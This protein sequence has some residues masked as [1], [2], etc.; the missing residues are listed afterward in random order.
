MKREGGGGKGTWV[1]LLDTDG[2]SHL[3]WN[4]PNHDSDCI[5]F[6]KLQEPY[7]LVGSAISPHFVK[8]L[9]SMAMD[10]H[11]KEK[12]VASVLLSALYA[13]VI[14][15]V[16]ISQ[17]S[18]LLLEAADDL[19]LGILDAVDILALFVARAVVDDILPPAFLSRAKKVLPESSKGVQVIQTADRATFQLLIMQNL[20][21]NAG[22]GSTH[23]TVEEVK[24]TI[25]VLLR[26]Y[27]GS[28]DTAEV[29][30]CIRDLGVLSSITR[31]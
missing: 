25:S 23:V 18:V 2:E 13:D 3:D 28:G 12:E 5:P 19:V 15:S 9:V 21:R 22:G 14:S 27:V 11:D 6:L 29:C 8:R 1:R 4:D 7:Q 24:K 17:G 20:W 16:H 10:R 31:L 30:R 26:D